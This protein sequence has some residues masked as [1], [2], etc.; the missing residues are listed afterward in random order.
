MVLNTHQDLSEVQVLETEAF[1]FLPCLPA[2]PF[3][4]LPGR[5]TLQLTCFRNSLWRESSLVLT[6]DKQA[7]SKP[8]TLVHGKLFPVSNSSS[9]L[10]LRLQLSSCHFRG[11]AL[12]SS[13]PPIT[14]IDNHLLIPKTVLD[15]FRPYLAIKSGHH[16]GTRTSLCIGLSKSYPLLPDPGSGSNE[17]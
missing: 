10:D 13:G 15:L 6:R 9:Y 5:L 1:L 14:L 16:T 8:F 17:L 12:T 3:Q 11:Y 2:G 4:V 7:E